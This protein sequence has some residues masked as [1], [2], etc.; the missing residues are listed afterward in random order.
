MVIGHQILITK[1]YN[2][3]KCWVTIRLPTLYP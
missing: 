1:N 2:N 3:Y